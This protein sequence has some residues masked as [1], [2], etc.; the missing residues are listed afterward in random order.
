MLQLEHVGGNT[1]C[2]ARG[3]VIGVHYMH[4]ALITYSPHLMI[5]WHLSGIVTVV[6]TQSARVHNLM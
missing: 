2:T 5:V 1:T 6:V 4:S 3:V